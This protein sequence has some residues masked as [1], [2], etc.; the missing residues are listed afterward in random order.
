M[1]ENPS[2]PSRP[3]GIQ[4]GSRPYAVKDFRRGLVQS[5]CTAGE[6]PGSAG[7]L[8]PGLAMPENRWERHKA[9][10]EIPQGGF[11]HGFHRLNETTLA[12]EQAVGDVDHQ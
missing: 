1:E 9:A 5:G 8:I 3:L 11:P 6:C 4:P 12:V 7:R 2:H 10:L